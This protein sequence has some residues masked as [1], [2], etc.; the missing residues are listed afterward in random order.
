MFVPALLSFSASIERSFLD[1]FISVR[2][3]ESSIAHLL[4][5][6]GPFDH[7]QH[8]RLLPLRP[9]RHGLHEHSPARHQT[10]ALILISSL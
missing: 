8:V 10:Y 6:T 1:L 2:L 5:T 7:H 4:Q 3:L 9:P